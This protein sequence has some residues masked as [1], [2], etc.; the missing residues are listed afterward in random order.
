MLNDFNGFWNIDRKRIFFVT[1]IINFGRYYYYYFVHE[2]I[3]AKNGFRENR[4]FS[5]TK[6]KNNFQ[7]RAGAIILEFGFLRARPKPY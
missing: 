2:I 4:T 7:R 5:R 3:T 1:G 6:M